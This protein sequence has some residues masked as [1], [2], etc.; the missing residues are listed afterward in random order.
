M[1]PGAPNQNSDRT[2]NNKG[3]ISK[4]IESTK[5]CPLICKT[6]MIRLKLAKSPKVE[7]TTKIIKNTEVIKSTKNYQLI[8]KIFMI[9]PKSPKVEK[10]AKYPQWAILPARKWTTDFP[11]KNVQNRIWT[12]ICLETKSLHVW[13]HKNATDRWATQ[14]QDH[15]TFKG[16]RMHVWTL[17][18]LEPKTLHIWT[19]G[20]PCLNANLL[21]AQ[22]ASPLNVLMNIWNHLSMWIYSGVNSLCIWMRKIE[23]EHDSP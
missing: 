16:T 4:I 2:V 9:Q 20:N 10:T 15:F 23:F 21:G 7:K 13:M 18:C 1:G 6:F 12:W 22:I 3:K 5:N 19:C 11:L 8:C 14:S 17:I